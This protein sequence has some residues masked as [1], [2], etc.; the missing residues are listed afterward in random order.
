MKWL[1][2][3]K[4]KLTGNKTSTTDLNA[5]S[6]DIASDIYIKELA[7]YSCT[8]RIAKAIT[9]CNFK[10]YV[11]GKEIKD[12]EYFLWNYSPNKNQSSDAFLNK[13]ITKLY[14]DNECLVIEIDKQLFVADSFDVI[15]N[16]IYG[17]SFRSVVVDELA[18]NRIFK[19]EEVLYFELNNKNIK[20]LLDSVT[21][22][23]LKLIEIS[24]K[25]YSKQNGIKGILNISQLAMSQADFEDRYQKLVNDQFKTYIDADNAVLPLFE[26]Y[27]FDESGKNASTRVTNTRD[28]KELYNDIL[29]FTARALSFP[30]SLAKGDVQDTSKAVDELLTFCIDPLVD[31]LATEINRKRYGSKK[32]SERTFIKI[33]TKTIKHID[34]FEFANNISKLVSS[35]IFTIN[36]LRLA[37]DEELIDEP[38]ADKV[39]MTK[40]FATIEE[41]L[42]IMKGGGDGEE[43]L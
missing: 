43:I 29:D 10:T 13:L 11:K 23:Y 34:L 16:T 8:N 27:S 14:E 5:I 15:E 25:Q 21:N 22:K 30:P 31:L 24:T 40:N 18:L 32:L 35:G 3:F 17:N 41:I 42:E 37:L 7:F 1:D 19:S 36:D 9:R 4:W 28:I 2:W 33:D 38:W 26:G 12:A 39:F 20:N 6:I